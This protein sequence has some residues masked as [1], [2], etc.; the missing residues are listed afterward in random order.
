MAATS[1]S[2]GARLSA[3]EVTVDGIKGDLAGI[4]KDLQV[5]ASEVRDAMANAEQ[6]RRPNYGWWIAAGGFFL[7]LISAIVVLGVQGPLDSIDELKT[8]AVKQHETDVSVAFER[9]KLKARIEIIEERQAHVVDRLHG[10]AQDGHPFTQGEQ[11]K[12]LRQ[13]IADL[14]ATQRICTAC[15]EARANADR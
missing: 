8:E 10:H 1:T 5:F 4:R 15:Q 9:G 12:S 14:Q 2:T 3:L 11:I 6:R 7:T 13:Q